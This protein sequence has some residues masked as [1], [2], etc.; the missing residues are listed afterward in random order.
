EDLDPVPLLVLEQLATV[1]T[2]PRADELRGG[3]G[4]ERRAAGCARP[5]R[6]AGC[7]RRGPFGADFCGSGGQGVAVRLKRPLA[8]LGATGRDEMPLAAL[9]RAEPL[10]KPSGWFLFAR[11]PAASA[12]HNDLAVPIG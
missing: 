11:D 1:T 3:L 8:L 6:Q 9:V 5:A 10:V 2:S 12:V 7:E 4:V